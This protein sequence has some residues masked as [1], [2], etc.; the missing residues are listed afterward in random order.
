MMRRIESEAANRLIQN[1]Q[2]QD[3]AFNTGYVSGVYNFVS[4]RKANYYAV[5]NTLSL[6][7]PL[8]R[9]LSNISMHCHER[10]TSLAQ[11]TSSPHMP[12]YDEIF[13]LENISRAECLRKKLWT[14]F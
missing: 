9:I 7:K 5:W 12:Y 14:Y 2:I 10:D 13:T 1:L 6:V 11:P 3:F 4:T 8:L